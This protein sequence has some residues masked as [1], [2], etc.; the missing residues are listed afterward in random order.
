MRDRKG[1]TASATWTD[2]WDAARTAP[3]LRIAEPRPFRAIFRTLAP[4]RR[5]AV[6]VTALIVFAA[7]LNLAPPLFVKRIVDTAIPERRVGMLVALCAAMVIGPLLAGLLQLA[8]RY[9]ASSV[10]EGVVLDLR[11][12]LFSHLQRQSVR[13]FSDAP[14]GEL[15]SRSLSDIQGIGGALSGTLVKAL[16]SSVVFLSSVCLVLF[17][18]WRLGLIAIAL[19]PTFIIPTR[20]VGAR[21]KAVKR[22]TQRVMAEL[23]GVLA[24]SLSV[25]GALVLKLFGGEQRHTARVSDKGRQLRALSLQQ[26]LLGRWFQLALGLFESAGPA[27][28]F[29]AGGFLIIHGRLKLGT[30]IAFVTVLKR[31][32]GSLSQLAGVHVDVVTSCAYFDRVFDVLDRTP[33]VQSRP[34]AKVVQNP[35]GELIFRGVCF[36]YSSAPCLRDLELTIPP[37]RTVAIVGPSGSGKSTLVALIPRLYDPTVGQILLDG[38]DLRDLDLES[39]RAHIAV[40][41]QD[42]FLFQGTIQENLAL[43]RDAASFD[44]I[45]K[46]ARAAGIHEMIERLPDG[47]ATVVGDRGHRLSGGERQRI[48]IAR[49]VLK[50]PRILIL[51]EAT[52][53]LDARTEAQIQEALRPLMRGRTTFVVAHR[54]STIRDADLIVVLDH[55][56]IVDAGSHAEL[57]GRAGLYARLWAH[58]SGI[59]E[60]GGPGP[61]APTADPTRAVTGGGGGGG[62]WPGRSSRTA[63]SP[64]SASCRRRA[65]G[66]S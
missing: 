33:D 48:S 10:A 52:S 51:D 8:E 63:R 38:H 20:R 5:R 26:T 54:L 46:A 56:R 18:D 42:T 45:V 11:V 30:V 62:A 6:L 50:N 40:V 31:L 49:A 23:T 44:E 19:L 39:L 53:A 32:Y 4:Y 65:R 22:R 7:V 37:G 2:P 58:Q 43:G 61:T 29:L 36:D 9:L 16:E 27:V 24:E 21:R 60:T 25:S 15:L 13:F 47:Y 17:L 3:R 55:G 1:A 41:T 28:I 64:A 34:G 59:V 66:S 57:L 35:P 12:G 14:P